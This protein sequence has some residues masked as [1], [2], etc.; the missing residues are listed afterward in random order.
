MLDLLYVQLTVSWR[1]GS[2]Q[3]PTSGQ[4]ACGLPYGGSPRWPGGEGFAAGPVGG[5]AQPVLTARRTSIGN[6]R[7]STA[8][9]ARASADAW[10]GPKG[11]PWGWQTVPAA[12]VRVLTR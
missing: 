11:E 8:A 12:G 5:P 10:I 1:R 4:G 7:P 3:P 9:L 2:P 6:V